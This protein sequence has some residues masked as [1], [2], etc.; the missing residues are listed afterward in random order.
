MPQDPDWLVAAVRRAESAGPSDKLDA[1]RNLVRE[2]RD[3]EAESQSLEE[4]L[5]EV[6]DRAARIK[7]T[8]LVDLMDE[9]GVSSITIP[10]EGNQPGYKAEAV[11]FYNANIAAGWS[12]EKRKAAFKWLDE[13]GHGGLIKTVVTVPFPRE[14]RKEVLKLAADLESRGITFSVGES[15]HPQTL[16]A[17]LRKQVEDGGNLPPLETIGA[18][19]GRTVKIK[20]G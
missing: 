2:L 9:A 13:N 17:W 4:R 11:P 19:I 3:L 10:P 7:N 14:L 15:V 12:Q 8:A 20:E 16:T 18:V 6:N 1:L 5:K